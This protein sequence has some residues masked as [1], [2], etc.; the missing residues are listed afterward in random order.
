MQHHMD[1]YQKKMGN[2]HTAK[3]RDY[4]RSFIVLMDLTIPNLQILY[5][6]LLTPL[7]IAYYCC[8]TAQIYKLIYINNRK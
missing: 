8:V 6:R 2:Y 4:P 7:V 3:E 1:S 5:S